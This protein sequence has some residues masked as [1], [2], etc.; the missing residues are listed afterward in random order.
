MPDEL[1]IVVE[2]GARGMGIYAWL[3]FVFVTARAL[4]LEHRFPIFKTLILELKP[5]YWLML[6]CYTYHV[7]NADQPAW[8]KTVNLAG[9]LATV[10]I[11]NRIDD[12]DRWKKRRKKLLEKVSQVAGRLVVTPA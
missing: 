6:P 8:V 11:V 10:W 4:G 7:M 5:L 2:I 1:M 3:V 9:A 12:D